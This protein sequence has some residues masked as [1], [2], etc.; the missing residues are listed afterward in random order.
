MSHSMDTWRMVVAAL[1]L[2]LGSEK[3]KGVKRIELFGGLKQEDTV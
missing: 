2:R 3:V 1:T